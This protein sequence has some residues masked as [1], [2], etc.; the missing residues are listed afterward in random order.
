MMVVT[1]EEIATGM[2]VPVGT[3][4]PDSSTIAELD[5][6]RLLVLNSPALPE[7]GL[8]F[9]S[10]SRIEFIEEGDVRT[11]VNIT[12][13]PYTAE[14]APNAKTGWQQQLEKLNAL[15]DQGR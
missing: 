3:E 11:R 9:D 10:T 14:M 12:S 7:A 5:P 6:P 13:G 2:G 4:F 8:I 15:L 1:S